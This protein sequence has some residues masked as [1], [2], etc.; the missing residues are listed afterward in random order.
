MQYMEVFKEE[1]NNLGRIL[2]THYVHCGKMF[3]D[4]PARREDFIQETGSEVFPLQFCQHRWVE[5]IKVANRNLQIWPHIDK[6]V[7]TVTK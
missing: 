3:H 5:D 7:K 6:Y 1:Q 4:V 2:P